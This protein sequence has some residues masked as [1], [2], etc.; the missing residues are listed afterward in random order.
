MKKLLSLFLIIF[1]SACEDKSTN[2]VYL[3]KTNETAES[4]GCGNI[5]VYQYLDDSKVLTVKIDGKNI[6]LKKEPQ[7][8]ILDNSN[9]YVNVILEIAGNDPDSIYFNFCNDV[10]MLNQGTTL[11]YKAIS[12]ELTFSVSEDNPI[13]DPVWESLYYV[14]VNIKK[15]HLYNETKGNEIVINEIV[16][17]N[18]RVG[19]LPG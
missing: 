1:I 14:T 11:K 12:G 3:L 8:I 10:L 16:F 6:S 5:F 18:V 17:S 7:T 19:W 9:P 4:Y 2:P 15:L 13:K